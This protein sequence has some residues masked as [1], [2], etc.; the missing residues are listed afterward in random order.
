MFKLVNYLAS[1]A[2][3]S[4]RFFSI[5]AFPPQ[6]PPHSCASS[7]CG[8]QERDGMSHGRTRS[9]VESTFR[10][11]YRFHPSSIRHP[12]HPSSTHLGSHDGGAD[13]G[14]VKR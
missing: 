1:C 2:L 5:S 8:A 11:V 12:F 3:A 9:F 10:L 7:S 4:C 6:L 13:D 14:T